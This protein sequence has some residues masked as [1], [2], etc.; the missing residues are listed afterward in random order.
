MFTTLS[1][2]IMC[3]LLLPGIVIGEIYKYYDEN[4]NVHYTDVDPSLDK[5][6]PNVKAVTIIDDVES[7][8]SWKRYDH[9][10]KQGAR[11][12]DGF[13]IESPQNGSVISSSNRNLLATVHLETKLSSVYRIKFY[14]DGVA[15][16]KVRSDSQL[17][18]DVTDGEH[19][20]YAELIEKQSRRVI[21]TSPE[22]RFRYI[23]SEK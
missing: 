19:T 21:V 23:K 18:A 14:L 5:T 17:I 3:L 13:E 9:K 15:R 4:G 22:I 10:K 7:K 16:G 8:S 12:F 20:L 6:A 11:L 2:L 1:R